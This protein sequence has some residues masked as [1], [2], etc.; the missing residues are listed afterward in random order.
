MLYYHPILMC[1]MRFHA[2]VQTMLSMMQN[3]ASPKLVSESVEDHH[4]AAR[5]RL[6]VIYRIPSLQFLDASPVTPTERAEARQKV[7]TRAVWE[8]PLCPLCCGTVRLCHPHTARH[9]AS[10]VPL[11][12]LERIPVA[13]SC[14]I[15]TP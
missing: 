7:R 11:L 12:V 3:P 9:V 8:A 1:K 5:Y 4:M 14:R 2:F 13:W 15:P 6:Y 10:I